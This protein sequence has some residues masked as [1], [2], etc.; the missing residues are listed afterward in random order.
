MIRRAAR[1]ADGCTSGHGVCGMAR[2]SPRSLGGGEMDPL[3]YFDVIE[4]LPDGFR[5]RAS[6]E[7]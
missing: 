4:A 5:V 6:L 7:V 2:L 3:A 1:I